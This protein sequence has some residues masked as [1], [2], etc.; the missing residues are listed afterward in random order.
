MPKANSGDSA[1]RLIA[2]LGQL[3]PGMSVPIEDLATSLG[4]STAQLADDLET[5]CVCGVAP[6]M[7]DQMLDVFVDDGMLEVYAPLPAVSAPVRLAPSESRALAAALSAAGFTGD[8]PL[9]ERLLSAAAASFDSEALERTLRSTIATHDSGVFET[10]ASAAGGSEV[11]TIA[12]QSDGA[13]EPTVRDVEPQ[14]LF[15]E[16]GAWYLSAWCRTAEGMRT[17]R[18]DRIRT[19]EKTGERFERVAMPDRDT[20][21]TAFAP[22]GLPVATLRFAPG[23]AFVAR[24][25]PGGR[26]V[27]TENDGTTVAEVPF[28]GTGWIARRVVARLGKV[29]AVAPAEVRRAV[30]ELAREELE[31]TPTRGV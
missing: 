15:A 13:A 28:G 6:Y 18:I 16:R 12:Y 21:P 24:E 17:F 20:G 4:T 1:R 30:A 19:A 29:E 27:S 22:E 5:L 9:S 3:T 8:D 31:R 14:Q 11:V 25:W 26:V 2:L 7:P 10:L 23:E